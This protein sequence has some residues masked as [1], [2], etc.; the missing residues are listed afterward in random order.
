[1]KALYF[2]TIFFTVLFRHEFEY[3][4]SHEKKPKPMVSGI[5][6][7]NPINAV[8]PGRVLHVNSYTEFRY[9]FMENHEFI[10]DFVDKTHELEYQKGYAMNSCAKIQA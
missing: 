1:M 2:F 9:K 7:W 4:L 8:V 10:C 3:D 5:N 6:S